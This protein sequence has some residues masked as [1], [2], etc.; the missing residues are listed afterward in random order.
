MVRNAPASWASTRCTNSVSSKIAAGACFARGWLIAYTPLP[1]RCVSREEVPGSFLAGGRQQGYF[2]ACAQSER[3]DCPATS[4]KYPFPEDAT[5][6]IVV[7]VAAVLS[8]PIAEL[9][10]AK[11]TSGRSR[12]SS[13]ACACIC[14]TL[15]PAYRISKRILPPSIQP[16]FCS[17]SRSATSRSTA[18]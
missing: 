12:T 2:N 6:G 18:S 3:K 5:M 11:R 8:A 9:A 17:P 7:V 15:P 13:A 1:H 4:S 14:S 10:A 16:R